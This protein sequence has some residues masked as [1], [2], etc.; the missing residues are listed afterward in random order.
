M[1]GGDSVDDAKT[2]RRGISPSL[3]GI[4]VV[5]AAALTFFWQNSGPI[6]IEFLGFTWDTTIRWSLSV[7]ALIGAL[8][9]RLIS[10]WSRRRR[11]RRAAA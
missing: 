9:D 1:A 3:V 5:A 10:L 7:A 6:T 8:L 4:V 2:P 11:R